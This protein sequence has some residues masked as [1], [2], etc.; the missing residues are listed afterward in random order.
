MLAHN[1]YF[2]VVFKTE[3]QKMREALARAKDSMDTY[4]KQHAAIKAEIENYIAYAAKH[5]ISE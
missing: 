1:A 4:T 3:L 5:G 2:D